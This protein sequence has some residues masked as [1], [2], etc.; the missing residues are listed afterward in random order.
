MAVK[1]VKLRKLKIKVCNDNYGLVFNLE[2]HS[3]EKDPKS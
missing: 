3:I 2:V 1:V